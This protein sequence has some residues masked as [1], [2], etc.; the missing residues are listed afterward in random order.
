MFLHSD[1][2]RMRQETITPAAVFEETERGGIIQP[3]GDAEGG[4]TW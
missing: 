3:I 2:R 1:R 4:T